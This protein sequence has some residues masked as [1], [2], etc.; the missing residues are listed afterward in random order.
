MCDCP[1]T[2]CFGAVEFTG[3]VGK[4]DTCG[5][6]FNLQLK[7]PADKEAGSGSQ[8][9]KVWGKWPG[10]EPIDEILEALKP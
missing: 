3:S 9:Q 6:E 2:K 1:F 7:S 8:L 5:S 10:D 4:C